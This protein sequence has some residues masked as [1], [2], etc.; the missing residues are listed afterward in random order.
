VYFPRHNAGWSVQLRQKMNSMNEQMKDPR[1][2]LAAER[3]LLAWI[4][5]GL[6]LMG[7]GFVLARFG[8][9]L[10]TLTPTENIRQAQSPH[11]S[12][13]SGISLIVAGVAVQIISLVQYR[14]LIHRLNSG[15]AQFDRPSLVGSAVAVLMALVGSAMA[16]YLI[17]FREN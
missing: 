2:Y 1:V 17:V 7:F 16:I 5:T 8:L 9:F 4:R 15:S 13:S 11:F 14:R 12:I 3:T 6:A 10:R